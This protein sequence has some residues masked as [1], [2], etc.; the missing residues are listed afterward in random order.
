MPNISLLCPLHGCWLGIEA[1]DLHIY[2]FLGNQNSENVLN[3]EVRFAVAFFE[4][5]CPKYSA[6]NCVITLWE[7]RNGDWEAWEQIRSE[8]AWLVTVES[9]TQMPLLQ[10]DFIGL[11]KT[12]AACVEIMS[13][14]LSSPCRAQGWVVETASGTQKARDN[15]LVIT[16]G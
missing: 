6:A 4:C 11:T 5:V 1:Y 16:P 2:S 7:E 10:Q 13:W 8:E 14:S 12:T 3:P 15:W 9:H